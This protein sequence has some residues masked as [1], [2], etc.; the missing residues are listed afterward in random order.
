MD[1]FL[2]WIGKLIGTVMVGPGA[3]VLGDPGLDYD[4]PSK[5]WSPMTYRLIGLGFAAAVLAI[6]RVPLPV[7]AIV[8]VLAAGLI[9]LERLMSSRKR[10]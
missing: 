2:A 3:V 4:P 6:A 9:G 8:L 7:I 10:G 1:R 5:P